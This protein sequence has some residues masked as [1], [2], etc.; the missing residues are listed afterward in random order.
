MPK[1]SISLAREFFKSEQ[2]L[3]ER[4]TNAMAWIDLIQ[5]ANWRRKSFTKGGIEIVVERGQLVRSMRYLAAR[6]KWSRK[7]VKKYLTALNKEKQIILACTNKY[8]TVT[9]CN[10]DKYQLIPRGH[11][12]QGAPPVTPPVTPP[13][14]HQLYKDEE[15]QITNYNNPPNPPAK[16]PNKSKNPNSGKT[17]LQPCFDITDRMGFWFFEQD[18]RYIEIVQA[19][20]QWMDYWMSEGKLKKDWIATWRNGMRK[21]EQWAKRDNGGE[22]ETHSWQLSTRRR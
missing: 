3:C 12:P 6:W 16:K 18:F 10:Y 11:A 22:E 4:F 17:K 20:E 21:A 15:L 5:L 8:T 9:I 14:T 13:L 1:P 7:T 19:T 2:W